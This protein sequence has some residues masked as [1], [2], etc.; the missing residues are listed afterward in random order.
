VGNPED[1]AH[2]V[3]YLAAEEAAFT[4]GQVIMSNGGEV[5]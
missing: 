5:M 4:T 2:A 1:V 3:L